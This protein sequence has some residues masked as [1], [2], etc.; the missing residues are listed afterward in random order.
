MSGCEASAEPSQLLAGGRI[1]IEVHR[2]GCPEDSRPCGTDCPFD[3]PA[4]IARIE[5]SPDAPRFRHLA[6]QVYCAGLVSG[7]LAHVPGG[8][9]ASLAVELERDARAETEG[10]PT[11]V[12]GLAISIDGYTW[13]VPA[14]TW[15]RSFLDHARNADWQRTLRVAPRY[16][17]CVT[18][19]PKPVASPRG[20]RRGRAPAW[21]VGRCVTQARFPVDAEALPLSLPDGTGEQRAMLEVVWHDRE[22]LERARTQAAEES[23]LEIAFLLLGSMHFCSASRTPFT[24]IRRVVPVTQY[25]VRDSI[26]AS[27]SPENYAEARA[28]ARSEGL[29]VVGILHSHVVESGEKEGNVSGLFYSHTD[30][31]DHASSLPSAWSVGAVLNVRHD[32]SVEMAAFAR[33]LDGAFAPLERLLINTSDAK[34]RKS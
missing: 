5:L 9:S 17:A 30:A 4:T 27:I 24:E 12:Q 3:A 19:S 15:T 28:A 29:D 22:G 13:T 16:W 8:G 14:E 1:A 11:L 18:W 10:D 34:E 25:E 32:G 23:P 31:E 21:K 6:E 33:D 7:Q 2:D 20:V 26:R